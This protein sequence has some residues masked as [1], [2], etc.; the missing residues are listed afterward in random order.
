MLRQT[1][2]YLRR[3]GVE[4]TATFQ[5]TTFRKS[6]GQNHADAGTPPKTLAK[7]MGHANVS[8]TMAFYNRVTD[9]NEQ[10]AAATIDRMFAAGAQGR[11]AEGA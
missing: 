1:Q 6:F 9:A 5:L 8:T 3:A 7:L 2:G 11:R 4:L 10:A